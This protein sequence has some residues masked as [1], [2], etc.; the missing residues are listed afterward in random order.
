[1]TAE[2][3]RSFPPA[4]IARRLRTHPSTTGP[5]LA[6]AAPVN[7]HAFSG[8]FLAEPAVALDNTGPQVSFSK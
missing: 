1:M 7:G 2:K 5:D 3:Y 8:A 4:A 6:I